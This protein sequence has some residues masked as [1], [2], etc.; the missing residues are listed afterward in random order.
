M[1]SW[2]RPAST[3][4]CKENEPGLRKIAG[5]RLAIIERPNR[6]L[7][8]I[9]AAFESKSTADLVKEKF[10]G[11]VEKLP[12]GWLGRFL[13]AKNAEPLRIGKRLVIAQSSRDWEADSFPHRLIIPAGAA[14]GTGEHATTAT[15]LKLLEELTRDWKPGWKIVDL[16]TGSG[17]LALAAT[18]FGAK[19]GIAID[20]DR[21]AIST[22]MENARLNRIVDVKF[23]VG[24]V[25]RLKFPADADLVTANLFNELLIEI[26]PKLSRSRFLILSGI[27][28]NLEGEVR[29]ALRRNKIRV[30]K[31]QRRGKWIAILSASRR[32]WSERS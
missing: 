20:R 24:D 19:R 26:L 21:M 12:R 14:F 29:S 27:L 18:H 30:I 22:A 2:R 28:R 4:W 5:E 10:G 6:K 9:E 25:R 32:A 1:Y 7:L 3:R 13:R 11:H 15:S 16:G 8:L 31:V 17:I 23:R